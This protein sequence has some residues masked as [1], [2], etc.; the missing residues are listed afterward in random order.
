MEAGWCRYEQC[1]DLDLGKVVLPFNGGEFIDSHGYFMSF[2]IIYVH[3][4]HSLFF[5]SYP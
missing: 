5:N 2:T 3:L 1:G 4:D